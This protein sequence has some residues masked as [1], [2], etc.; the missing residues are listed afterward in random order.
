[1]ALIIKLVA[2]GHGIALVPGPVAREAHDNGAVK[3]LNV[4]PAIPPIAYYVSYLQELA[5][6]AREN[7]VPLARTVFSECGLIYMPRKRRVAS[8]GISGQS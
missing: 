8:R 7:L 3:L 2:A 6:I 1:M 5:P 4:F